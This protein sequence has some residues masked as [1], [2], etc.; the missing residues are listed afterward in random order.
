MRSTFIDKN[1]TPYIVQKLKDSVYILTELLTIRYCM[2][3][4]R[5]I[6]VKH[7]KNQPRK[8]KLVVRL[9]IAKFRLAYLML[10][11]SAHTLHCVKYIISLYK[12]T[13]TG[14]LSTNLSI[15]II[16][17]KYIHF[18]QLVFTI[19]ITD[20]LKDNT[21]IESEHRSLSVRGEYVDP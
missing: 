20:N 2:G 14:A 15:Y 21:E 9:C 3:A 18:N 19:I 6:R 11:H 8:P 12:F 1:N 13:V 16:S 4:N 5:K 17:F 7:L 10:E